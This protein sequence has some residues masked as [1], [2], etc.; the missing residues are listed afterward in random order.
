MPQLFA[1][2][3]EGVEWLTK[4]TRAHLLLADEMGL[5]KTPQAIEAMDSL[6]LERVLIVAPSVAKTNWAREIE[7]F[8]LYGR[9]AQVMETMKDPLPKSGTVICS[10]EFATREVGRLGSD[11]DLVVLDE[12]H[13]AIN[14]NAKRTQAIFGRRGNAIAG[15]AGG[16]I[17]R[18][19]RMWCLTGTPAPNHWGELWILLKTFGQTKLSYDQFLNHFC[20]TEASTY[21]IKVLGGNEFRR[22]ELRGLLAPIMMRRKKVDVLK[23]L[24]PISFHDVTVNAGEVDFD[25]DSSLIGYVFPTDRRQEFFKRIETERKLIESVMKLT[26]FGSDGVNAL[27]G[28]S[29]SVS[30]LRRYTGMQKVDETAVLIRDE[31]EF[32]SYD[33]VVIFAIHQGVIEGMRDK[34]R[35]FHPVVLYGKTPPEK[36]QR[37]IDRFQKDPSCRVFIGNIKACGTAITLTAAHNVVFVEQEWAPGHN[38]QAAMRCHR[39]GQTRPVLV[40][41]VALANS[42]D[43]RVANVLKRKTRDAA[44]ILD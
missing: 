37:R 8:S 28:I 3:R 13:F 38:A 12:S 19:R 6:G 14:A 32:G 17:H 29:D 22:D 15:E 44:S 41:F 24:P 35:K 34:L 16:L 26:G 40:R 9:R 4:N 25:I 10:Y 31:L 20:L 5:G 42:I 7:K 30:T 27:T 43:Q 11:W 36:R 39:I 21:G 23:E 33:K 1:Y 18:T 2:Q